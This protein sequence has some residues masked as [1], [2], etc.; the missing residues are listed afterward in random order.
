MSE[1]RARGVL[2]TGGS[3]YVG[4]LI[5]ATLL[6]NEDVRIVAPVR[7]VDRDRFLAP[8][9]AEVRMAG[10]C[11]DEAMAARVHLVEFPDRERLD[12]LDAVM[13]EHGVDEIIH[14]AGCLDYFN[15]EALEQANVDLT[16]RLVEYA[17]RR[18]V[19]RFIY[20]STAFSVGYVFRTIPE[21]LHTTP[22]KDPTEYTRTKREAEAIIAASGVPYLILRPAIIIGDSRDGHYSGKQYGLYQLWAGMERLLCREWHPEVHVLAPRQPVQLVHQDA[23]QSAFLAAYR[24]LPPDSIM[25]LVSDLETL[26]DMRSLW[27]LWLGACLRPRTTFYYENMADIPLRAINGKQRALLA[28]ASV[29]LQIASHP[30]RFE[31]AN[32]DSLRSRGMSFADATTGTVARCQDLF[33]TE[34]KLIQEFLAVHSPSFA[35]ETAQVVIPAAAADV[36]R[37]DLLAAAS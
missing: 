15:S 13:D 37:G 36:A 31:T 29:N 20:L 33:I 21:A 4:G 35:A 10:A 7:K 25:N 19:A 28:L 24:Y 5:A 34:S 32:L 12:E 30:W 22:G 9:A 2:L 18:S 27:D 3:G 8:V 6:T 16:S 17:R 11:F 1:R 14:C 23:F 26:P